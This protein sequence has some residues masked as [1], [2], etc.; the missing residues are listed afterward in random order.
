MIDR[1][2]LLKE[3]LSTFFI[4]FLELFL[5]EVVEYIEPGSI[6]FLDKEVFT[7]VTAGKKY[8]TDLLVGVQFRGEPSFFRALEDLKKDKR[9]EHL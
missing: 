2:R 5:P 3:L 1:D 7:D 9:S 4:E 6:T 8:E